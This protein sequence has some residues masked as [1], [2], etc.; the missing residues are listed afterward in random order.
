MIER[1]LLFTLFILAIALQGRYS[2]LKAI[3]S[4]FANGR[5]KD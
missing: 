1:T 3:S 2:K 4:N 5:A